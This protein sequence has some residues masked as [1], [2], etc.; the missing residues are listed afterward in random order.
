MYL[1]K[2]LPLFLLLTFY[3]AGASCKKSTI[4]PA[5]ITPANLVVNATPSTDGSGKVTFTASADNAAVYIYNFGNGTS[6]TSNNGAAEPTV[7]TLIR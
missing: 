6:F 7:P 4:P 1:S 2:K 5:I 3:L